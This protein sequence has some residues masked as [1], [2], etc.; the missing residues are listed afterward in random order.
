V[1]ALLQRPVNRRALYGVLV[2]KVSS[3][4]KDAPLY[5]HN[6]ASRFTPAS[7]TKLF[8]TGSLFLHTDATS[9]RYSTPFLFRHSSA[10]L[11][12]RG[13]ADPS[14][15]HADLIT[16]AAAYARLASPWCDH[17]VPVTKI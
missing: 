17:S 16:A 4:G 15:A 7:N 5:A 14:L 1:D 3:G 2:R 6:A 10:Q 8:S 11:C 9:F 12:V 13:G